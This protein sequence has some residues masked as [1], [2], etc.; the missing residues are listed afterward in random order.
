MK[1]PKRTAKITTGISPPLRPGAD[2]E[3]IIDPS[4]RS[5]ARRARSGRS[6]LRGSAG[7]WSSRLLGD[8]R[9]E[10]ARSLR[11]QAI[12]MPLVST[13]ARSMARSAFIATPARWRTGS[14]PHASDHHVGPGGAA[15]P[16]QLVAATV[17]GTG[18]APGG[19]GTGG[20]PVAGRH[21]G[22]RPSRRPCPIVGAGRGRAGVGWRCPAVGEGRTSLGSVRELAEDLGFEPATSRSGV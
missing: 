15:G 3:A 13:A 2:S 10:S 20:Y 9:R 19:R 22:H 21:D 6:R 16:G 1:M 4:S 12:V 14:P 18:T 11:S 7:R 5:A 17:D 8:R